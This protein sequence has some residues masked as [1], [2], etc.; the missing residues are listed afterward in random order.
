MLR[1]LLREAEEELL[2]KKILI[3][4]DT[5]RMP[6]VFDAV[7]AYDAGVDV[8][9]QQGGI[10]PNEVRDLVY[11]AMF[12]R[13]PSDLKNTAVFIGGINVAKGEAILRETAAAFFDPL[14]VS[15]ML[16]ANGCNT[17]AAAAVVKVIS[18]VPV[19]GRKVVVLA[20][21]GPV[22]QRVA[23]L[24]TKEGAEV[25]LTSRNIDK[26]TAACTALKN[27]FGA[28]VH[29][30]AVADH[31]AT[32]G[33]L[34]N[35]CAAVCTGVEGVMLIPERIWKDHP[36][37]RILADVNAVPPLGIEGSKSHWDGQEINGKLLLGAIGIGGLKMK[38]HKRSIVRLFE[39]NDLILDAEEIMAI[40]KELAQ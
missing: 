21:T 24:L 13:G 37:L 19:R 11:G 22:G 35:A 16:D 32:A 7:T 2:M 12:T 9:L 4:F 34:E 31:A 23:A 5:D 20:G 38:V 8:L 3:Q 26:A 14:R 17:T 1:N 33:I 36:T 25:T 10:E 15:V 39:R 30:A 27:R 6:S 18:A 40:A 29:P 28:T